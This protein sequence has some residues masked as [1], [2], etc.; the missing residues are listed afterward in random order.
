MDTGFSDI[1]QVDWDIFSVLH[2]QDH[3]VGTLTSELADGSSVTD[4]VALVRVVIPECVI[5]QT[6][7]CVS[8]TVY[9][10]KDLL[11]VG[12]Q[13]LKACHA[14]IDYPREQTTLSG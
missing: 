8:N 1:M 11:L 5:D 10:C 4:L 6:M 9:Y 2:L 14:V 12:S 13:F 7:R 3:T